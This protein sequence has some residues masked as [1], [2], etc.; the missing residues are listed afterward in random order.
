MDRRNEELT[1]GKLYWVK[2]IETGKGYTVYSK[3]VLDATI[4]RTEDF[5]KKYYVQMRRSAEF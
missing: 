2:N 1:I 3:G 5:D 4:E